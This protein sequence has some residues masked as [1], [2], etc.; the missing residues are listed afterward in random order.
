MR[1]RGLVLFVAAVLA[2]A[3]GVVAAWGGFPNILRFNDPEL[4]YESGPGPGGLTVASASATDTTSAFGDPRV[5]VEEIVVVG[6]KEGVETSLTADYE[7][8]YVCVNGG[9]NVPSAANKVT[10]VGELETSAA[11]P[12]AKNGKAT[13][14]LLTGALPSAAEAAAATGFACPSGQVLE[15]D[16][17]RFFGLVLSVAGGETIQLDTTFVSES[18]HGL[19][20]S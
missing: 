10:L 4:V 17:V 5:L 11:F 13:G 15:F 18:V 3:V 2:G 7:A 20:V 9:A 12:A 14:S 1:R 19:E 8:V 6:I 16:H